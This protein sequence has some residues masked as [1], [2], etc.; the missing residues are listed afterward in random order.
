MDRE[1]KKNEEGTQSFLK[2]NEDRPRGSLADVDRQKEKRR[3]E[4][5]QTNTETNKQA[6]KGRSEGKKQ[7]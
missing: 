7:T 3:K 2:R 5:E 6:N 1:G 4:T